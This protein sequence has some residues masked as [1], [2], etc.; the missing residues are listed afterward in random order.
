MVCESASCAPPGLSIWK[1]RTAT[2]TATAA[3][4]AEKIKMRVSNKS[5]REVSDEKIPRQRAR[6]NAP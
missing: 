3:A 6:F 2:I 1:T 5:L 4:T